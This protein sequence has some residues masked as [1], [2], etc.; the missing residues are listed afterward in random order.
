MPPGEVVVTG[1]ATG[2]VTKGDIPAFPATDMGVAIAEGIGVEAIVGTAVGA[3]AG[4]L[5]V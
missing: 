1:A 5:P 2:G 4:V 3:G